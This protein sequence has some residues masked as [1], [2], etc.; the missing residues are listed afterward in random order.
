MK[1]NYLR[2][3][4]T[5]AMTLPAILL[6]GCNGGGGEKQSS[7]EISSIAPSSSIDVGP[8][9]VTNPKT[10]E[11]NLE[12]PAKTSLNG[13]FTIYT[14]AGE[15]PELTMNSKGSKATEIPC[16]Y[17]NMYEAIRVAGYNSTSK[18][19]LQVQDANNVQIFKR[20]KKSQCYVFDGA[21]YVG[22]SAGNPAKEYCSSHP[23]SYA[24]CGDASDYYYLGRRD[25]V[26]GQS[27]D[28]T[29][30][31]TPAGAYNYMFSKGGKGGSDYG[32]RYATAD[33]HL[34][35]ATYKR[36]TD[37][38]E[39]NAYIFINMSEGILSDLGLIG[40]I[41]NDK[42]VWFLVRNCSSK[43]HTA[44]TSS[45][46]RDSKFYVYQDANKYPNCLVTQSKKYDVNTGEFSGF[47]DL[48][49]EAFIVD[50]GWVLNITNMTTKA[51]STI[52]DRH[53]NETGGKLSE[54]TAKTAHNGRALIAASYCPVTGVIWNWNSGAALKN[55][56]WDNIELKKAIVNGDVVDNDI[57]HY[58]DLEKS[59]ELYPGTEAYRDGYSQGGY[60]AS[61]VYATREADGVYASGVS[62]K[63]G[64][65]YLSY[66]VDYSR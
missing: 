22:T 13:P 23:E 2:K 34:S 40:T 18:K 47:D 46:E 45:V 3:I 44:G 52:E 25:M 55:V 15:T 65:K 7:E 33:V 64:Q 42:C 26:E 36:P 27:V 19:V 11:L 53:T 66:S 24:I 1:K 58:R 54:N 35:E 12:N 57:Q 16:V 21:D 5:L 60:K 14:E 62:Y 56:V 30:L 41:R 28:E 39:W 4:A 38:G 49:F 43:M 31:E 50:D 6:A 59:Y 9:S 48:H 61:H 29:V 20:M 37:G 17:D 8:I 63:K 51:V 10:V 32:Y